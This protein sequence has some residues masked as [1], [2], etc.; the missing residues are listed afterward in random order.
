[1]W[2][3]EPE[4]QSRLFKGYIVTCARNCHSSF[5]IHPPL[6]LF[7]ILIFCWSQGHQEHSQTLLHLVVSMRPCFPAESGIKWY[8]WVQL[9]EPALTGREAPCPPRSSILL[10]KT[11]PATNSGT[12]NSWSHLIFI[13]HLLNVD[14]CTEVRLLAWWQ[15]LTTRTW[16]QMFFSLCFMYAGNLSPCEHIFAI[17]EY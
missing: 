13:Q 7:I 17:T 4:F 8:G 9:L 16:Q 11:R 14:Y 6:L 12:F 1:M 5:D 10:P 2:I 15:Q 3:L